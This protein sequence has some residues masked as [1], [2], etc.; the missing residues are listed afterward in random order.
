[1]A[2]YTRSSSNDR[3]SSIN[4]L[5]R[6]L[7]TNTPLEIAASS[8]SFLTPRQRSVQEMVDQLNSSLTA[9]VSAQMDFRLSTSATALPERVFVSLSC[10][11]ASLFFKAELHTILKRNKAGVIH[12]MPDAARIG[13]QARTVL[14]KLQQ[15]PSPPFFVCVQAGAMDLALGSSQ[16]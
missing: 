1:M 6:S 5:F 10:L 3:S 13:L 8:Q 16:S 12:K 14:P 15:M 9:H 11:N 4:T 7:G 2:S